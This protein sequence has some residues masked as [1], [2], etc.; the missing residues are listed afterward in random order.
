MGDFKKCFFIRTRHNDNILKNKKM[1][2][3]KRRNKKMIN[4]TTLKF[5]IKTTVADIDNILKKI[6][7]RP[8]TKIIKSKI[9][10][11]QLHVYIAQ[12]KI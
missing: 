12:Y 4:Y 2:H 7:C 8:F 1:D 9:V 6:R 10:D 5:N 11:D 3:K